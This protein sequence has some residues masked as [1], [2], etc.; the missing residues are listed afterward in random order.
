MADGGMFTHHQER[1]FVTRITAINRLL[2]ARLSLE[3]SLRRWAVEP[4]PVTNHQLPVTNLFS[5]QIRLYLFFSLL[6]L[7]AAHE[8]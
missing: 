8:A 5:G 3:Q 2:Q 1:E 6:L 7:H 4:L